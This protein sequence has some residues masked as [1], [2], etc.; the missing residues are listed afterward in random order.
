[1]QLA[2]G[3]IVEGKVS[4]IKKFGAFVDL[5]DGVSGLVHI[6]EIS[7]E[8]VESVEDYLKLDQKVKVKVLSMEGGKISLTMKGLGEDKKKV[9]EWSYD[10]GQSEMSFED[11]ISRFMK[12]SN[13]KYAQLRMRD[14][15][16]FSVKRK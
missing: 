4:G 12:D 7:E 8:Y 2:E 9:A 13:E 3:A 14:N 6:S 1:M 15:K 5:G 10:D 16:R 11:K